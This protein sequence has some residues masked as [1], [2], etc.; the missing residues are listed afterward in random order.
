MQYPERHALPTLGN[1]IMHV[2]HALVLVSLIAHLSATPCAAAEQGS[3]PQPA[4]ASAADDGWR[5]TIYPILVWVPSGIDI[6]ASLPPGDGDSGFEGEII[7]TRF[8]GAF[9]GGLSL[10]RGGW[11]LDADGVRAGWAA[12]GRSF[13]NCGSM[14]TSSTS[15]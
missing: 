8:D 2:I 7:E 5:I 13:R 15:T 4:A 12:T 1:D 14:P 3:A 11:R 6:D 10:E 9:L